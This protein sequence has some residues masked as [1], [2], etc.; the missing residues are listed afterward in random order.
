MAVGLRARAP[1]LEYWSDYKGNAALHWFNGSLWAGEAHRR[2]TAFSP[3]VN[4][5]PKGGVNSAVSISK[6]RLPFEIRI[7]KSEISDWAP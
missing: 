1:T 4:L 2:D 5:E 7:E 3:Q 6:P